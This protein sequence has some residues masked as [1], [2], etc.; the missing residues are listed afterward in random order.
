[1]PSLPNP[2]VCARSL[3]GRWAKLLLLEAD[4][5]VLQH[6]QALKDWPL[7]QLSAEGRVLLDVEADRAGEYYDMQQV[8]RLV[9]GFGASRCG[10]HWCAHA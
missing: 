4:E 2:C 10:W 9:H 8:S 3:R 6:V 5:D 1:L 7:E